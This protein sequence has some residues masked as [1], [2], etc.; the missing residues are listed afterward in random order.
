[1]TKNAGE[2]SMPASEVFG[3]LKVTVRFPRGLHLRW[4]VASWLFCL[5][6][7]IAGCGIEIDLDR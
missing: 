2:M 5:G 7:W 1:M 4:K 3:N 6:A